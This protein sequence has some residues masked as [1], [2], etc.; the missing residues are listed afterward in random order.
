MTLLD[1]DDDDEKGRRALEYDD[2]FDTVYSREAI[3]PFYRTKNISAPA[4]QEET[5]RLENEI[6]KYIKKTIMQIRSAL[7]LQ[8]KFRQSNDLIPQ[9]MANFLKE[10][11]NY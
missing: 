7:N 6:N 4:K 1:M 2:W 3:D 11:E 9:L 8:T 5:E 10:M